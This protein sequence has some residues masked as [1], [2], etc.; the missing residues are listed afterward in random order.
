MNEVYLC[1]GGN[2]GN[3]LANLNRASELIADKGGRIVHQSS[4]YQSQAWGMDKA[5]DFFNKA[6]K[7]ETKLTA[8]DLIIILLEIEKILGRERTEVAG[9]QSRIMDIDILFFNNE[10]IKTDVLEIPHPRLHLRNFVLL[11]LEEIASN[12]IHPI[13]KKTITELVKLSPDTGEIKKLTHAI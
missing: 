12:F 7:V 10:V 8:K 13:L 4:V 1:L 6:I 11:P 3:C 2:L 9:Y 5:P